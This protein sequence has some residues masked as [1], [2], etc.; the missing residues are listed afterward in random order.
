M[1]TLLGIALAVIAGLA[2]GLAINFVWW[3]EDANPAAWGAIV[4]IFSYAGLRFVWKSTKE[5]R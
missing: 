1:K 3:L 4:G 5:I 2:I